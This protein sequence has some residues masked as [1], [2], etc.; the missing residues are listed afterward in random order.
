VRVR[1]VAV[2][3]ICALLNCTIVHA[4]DTSKSGALALKSTVEGAE[5]YVDGVRLGLTPLRGSIALAPGEHTYKVT[6]AGFAPVIDVFRITRRKISKVEVEM[7]PVA[8]VLELA[9][10]IVD[11]RVYVDGK[12]VGQT[13]VKE[14]EVP[15]GN[16]SLL[17]QKGGYRDAI[18]KISAVAGE[19]TV[20][21]VTLEEL[22]VGINPYKPL[23][24]APR[25]WYEKWWVWT[26]A[27]V[28]VA[29]VATAIVVPLT[30][31]NRSSNVCKNVDQC[32]EVK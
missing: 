2:A 6:K 23:P 1:V 17:V 20:L 16:H 14:A 11:A 29:A 4:A 10:N 8:G 21:T 31:A 13:P 22:P 24:P 30:L 27:G 7:L 5:V 3:I 12:F 32:F 25:K 15:I 28:S 18:R 26:I 19:R 9:C